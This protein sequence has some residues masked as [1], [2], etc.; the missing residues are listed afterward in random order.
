VKPKNHAPVA[1]GFFALLCTI[2]APGQKPVLEQIRIV[3]LLG[4]PLPV[5]VAQRHETFA[6]HGIEVVNGTVATSDELR[7]SVAKGQ[8]DLAIAAVDNAVAMVE[9]AG[10]DVAIVM[11]GELSQNELFVQPDFHSIAELRGRIVIVDAPNTAYALQLKKILM[12][13]GL[14]PDKDYEI[15]SVGST[16]HRLEAMKQ[17]REFAGT[18]LGPPT[19]IIAR[20]VGLVSLGTTQKL[21]GPYQGLGDFVLREWARSHAALLENYL[22]ACIEAQ[23]WLMDPANK[24]QAIEIMVQELHLAPDVAAEYYVDLNTGYE[25]DAR[26]DLEGFKNVLKL[27][28]EVEGQWGGHPPGAEKYLDFSY[29]DAALLKAKTKN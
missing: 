22:A 21:I 7:G 6:A 1:I 23:R 18:M 8:S 14:T 11:G 24:Q 27:R 3:N 13:G 12:L 25:T 29:Y 4:R 20:K 10:T 2:S 26:L 17:H 9:T 15:R 28:A 16:P 19:S 5:I